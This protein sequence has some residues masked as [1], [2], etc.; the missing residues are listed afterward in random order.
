EA[1]RRRTLRRRLNTVLLQWFLLLVIGSGTVLAFSFVSVRRNLIEDRLVLARTIAH[2]LDATISTAIQDLG[3]LSSELPALD[4]DTAGRL[5]LFRFQ[6]P[7]REAT[8][9]LDEHAKMIVSDPAGAAPLPALRLGHHEAVTPLVRKPGAEQRPVLAI[10]QPFRRPPAVYYLVSEMNPLGSM[11]SAFLQDLGPDPDM[12]V[13]VVDENGVVV[14]SHDQRQ[15]FR[16][17]PHAETYGERIRAH[18]PLVSEE[19][20][21]EFASE[22]H[23]AADVLMVMVPLRFAPWGVVIQQ[24]QTK[25]FSG[26]YAARRGLLIAG[27]MLVVMA[28]LLARTLSKS[29]V[30]PIQQLSRQAQTMRAGDLSRRITVSGDHEVELLAR[31]LDEA[32]ER[33]RT[34]LGELQALNENLEGQVAARTKLIEA[35]YLDLRLL[36][37][38][39]QLSTEERDPDRIVPEMLRLISAH[40]AFPAA[41]IVTRP[42]ERE[43]ATYVVPPGA[44]L[45]WLTE[46][47]TP[48]RG[49]TAAGDRPSRTS[50]GRAVPS[51]RGEPGRAGH[52]G[53]RAPARDLAARGLPLEPHGRPGRAAAGPRP[54]SAPGDGGGAPPARPRAARR[55]LPAPDRHPALAPHG[56]RGD[57]GDDASPEPAGEGPAGDAPHH[58]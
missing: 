41:A 8:Y 18:R 54:A 55:D 6:S 48:P 4:A 23:D 35:K 13:V 50:A 1:M 5:R 22:R 10:V 20:Q 28:V 36:H 53:A 37:A 43:S 12:H 15:I 42:L 21:C 11:V 29:V 33:L 17:L 30:S 52:A 24:H 25:A 2:Y 16:I 34:T 38:V 31:T 45:P 46:G 3:R 51:P 44:A 57:A 26:V 49:L 47:R 9:I 56:R 58:P 27:V 14:A 40:Y 32:R 7:F 19:L 39:S